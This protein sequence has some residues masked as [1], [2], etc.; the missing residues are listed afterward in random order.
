MI[1]IFEKL[2]QRHSFVCGNMDIIYNLKLNLNEVLKSKLYWSGLKYF[3]KKIELMSVKV[4]QE[5]G[6]ISESYWIKARYSRFFEGVYMS[7]IQYYS[8]LAFWECRRKEGRD[9]SRDNKRHSI[10][11]RR[12]RLNSINRKLIFW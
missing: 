4:C 1:N 2:K 11:G 5:M 6:E 12:V 9:Y 10:G 8:I 7:K 3:E